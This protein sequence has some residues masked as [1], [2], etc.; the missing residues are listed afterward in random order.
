MTTG[1]FSTYLFFNDSIFVYFSRLWKKYLTPT[2]SGFE[3]FNDATLIIRNWLFFEL[4][5]VIFH[6]QNINDNFPHFLG[7]LFSLKSY[8]DKDPNCQY[9]RIEKIR[10]LDQNSNMLFLRNEFSKIFDDLFTM[11]ELTELTHIYDLTFV[12]FWNLL[13]LKRSLQNNSC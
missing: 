4:F 1:T 10:A 11:T 6:Y 12:T 8:F 7:K 9:F 13:A 5:V 3:I 2:L